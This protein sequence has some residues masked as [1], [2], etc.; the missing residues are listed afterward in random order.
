MAEQFTIAG[1]YAEIPNPSRKWWQFWKP[2]LVVSDKLMDFRVVSE[3]IATHH[4]TS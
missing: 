4:K 3:H 2:R 1:V